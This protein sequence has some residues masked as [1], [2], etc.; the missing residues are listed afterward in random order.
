LEDKQEKSRSPNKENMVGLRSSKTNLSISNVGN[1]SI[2]TLRNKRSNIKEKP[3]HS[4]YDQRSSLSNSNNVS[5]ISID[6]VT[7]HR[8]FEEGES[9]T[10]S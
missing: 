10:G 9:R 3:T 1:L 6:K 4:R 2:F 5:R 7:P 8:K